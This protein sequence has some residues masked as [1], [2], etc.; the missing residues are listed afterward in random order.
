M[1][2][3]VPVI[4]GCVFAVV[5]VPVFVV[6]V[7]VSPLVAVAAGVVLGA[8]AAALVWARADASVLRGLRAR[9]SDAS[10]DPRLHNVLGGLCD[11][12]GFRRPS[13]LVVEDPACNGAAF[14]R[15]HHQPH[16]AVTSGA[17]DG[18]SRL[19]LE[20]FLARLLVPFENPALAG[21]TVVVPVLSV[22]P[23]GL[24]A[25]IQAAYL[26]DQ[27]LLRDD[28]DAARLTRYPPGLQGAYQTLAAGGT[29]LDGVNPAAAHLWVIPLE[30]ATG[31]SPD[32]PSLVERVDA[33]G[34]L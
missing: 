7:L 29:V 9:P 13:V 27:R 17:V 1:L 5:F 11:S 19:E 15:R 20:G 10:T 3:R 8:A 21:A 18:L 30:R 25:R 16:L 2:A 33:L 28:F 14:G 24:R 12:H 26:A 32:N 4:L 22:L 6:L 34:E 31:S 23:S